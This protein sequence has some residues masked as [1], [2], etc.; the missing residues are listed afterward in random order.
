MATVSVGKP[1]PGDGV[2]LKD[3]KRPGATVTVV[4]LTPGDHGSSAVVRWVNPA[5]PREP[6]VRP[7]DMEVVLVQ[8]LP[9]AER[10]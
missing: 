7:E 8:D 9:K 2:S 4:G 3:W 5:T 10:G 6:R 1:R